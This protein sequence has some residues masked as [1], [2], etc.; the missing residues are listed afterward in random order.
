LLLGF[1]WMWKPQLTEDISARFF[2]SDIRWISSATGHGQHSS[3]FVVCVVLFVI[4]VVLLLIVMFYVLFMCK[5][6]LPP[7]VNPIAVDKC[8]K[9]NI[10]C[11]NYSHQHGSQIQQ[12]KKVGW[13]IKKKT[14]NT[15]FEIKTSSP[16]SAREFKVGSIEMLSFQSRF[17][18]SENHLS[19]FYRTALLLHH[20]WTN[21][22]HCLQAR[23]TDGDMNDVLTVMFFGFLLRKRNTVNL[24]K[25]G[26]HSLTGLVFARSE[27]FVERYGAAKLD[28]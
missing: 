5:C 12:H 18:Y 3:K 1:S 10:F 7:G 28:I 11:E 17:V 25:K 19:N 24:W 14:D 15:L 21:S 27:R 20:D 4:R 6:V 16:F 2:W 9:I 26:R 22:A 23:N 8:I 13:I